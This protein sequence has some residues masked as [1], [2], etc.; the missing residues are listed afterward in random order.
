[1]REKSMSKFNTDYIFDDPAV[2]VINFPMY[3]IHS[4]RVRCYYKL[5][6]NNIDLV[7]QL[8]YKK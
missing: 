2:Q 7:Q 3:Y 1:M 4:D 6:L 5:K 8:L